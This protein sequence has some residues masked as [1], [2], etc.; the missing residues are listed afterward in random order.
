[1]RR[2]VYGALIVAAAIILA[3]APTRKVP[4]SGARWYDDDIY[5][6]MASGPAD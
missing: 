1:M 4:Q 6:E 5:D 2:W 3:L